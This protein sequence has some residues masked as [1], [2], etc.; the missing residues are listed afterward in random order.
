MSLRILLH[1]ISGAAGRHRRGIE[2]VL[3]VSVDHYVRVFVR[4]FRSPRAALA[5]AKSRSCYVLQS[6]ECPSFFL[7]GALP[8]IARGRGGAAAGGGDGRPTTPTPTP[9]V[10]GLCP[11][12]G[13]ALMI[14][15]PMWSGPLHDIGWVSRA[16]ALAS[17]RGDGSRGAG[18][19][20][21]GHGPGFGAGGDG[22]TG[23][24]GGDDPRPRL[25]ARERVESVLRAVSLELPDVPLFYNLRDVFATVGLARSPR[26][27]QVIRARGR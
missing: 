8:K 11:E 23:A 3:S 20:G 5:A 19:P 15:G 14:G 10:V 4:V 18:A 26:R 6:Q 22:R 27:E 7:L 13:G 1:A 16:I 9:S 2:P 25:V 12:T 24:A 17:E 21:C